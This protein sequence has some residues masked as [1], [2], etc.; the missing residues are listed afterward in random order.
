MESSWSCFS[1]DPAS[2]EYHPAIGDN[3]TWGRQ[4]R[5]V[6]SQKLMVS[7]SRLGDFFGLGLVDQITR[8]CAIFKAPLNNTF[9]EFSVRFSVWGCKCLNGALC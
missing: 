9:A 6:S 3:D 1:A 8:C 4:G 7:D 5:N 2:F